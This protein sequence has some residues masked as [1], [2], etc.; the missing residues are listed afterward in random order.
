M[1]IRLGLAYDGHGFHGF[2]AQPGLRTVEGELRRALG[3]VGCRVHELRVAGRTDAG[4][5]AAGQVV[6]IECDVGPPID[7][8]APVVT[9]RLPPDIVVARAEPA[10][11]GFHARHDARGRAYVYRVLAR[12]VRDP[13]RRH[14]V[15]HVPREMDLSR[16]DAC[17]AVLRG[18]HDFR[19]FTPTETQHED[20]VRTVHHASWLRRDDELWFVVAGDRFVR[21]QVRTMVG[22]MLQVGLGEA[23]PEWFK[24]LLT[25][26][27]RADGGPTAPPH[28]LTLVGVRFE[29]EPFG[30]EL[31]GILPVDELSPALPSAYNQRRNCS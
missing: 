9:G 3:E 19:A 8:L 1:R 30:T 13:F 14:F 23:T 11:P 16:L 21:H 25:A 28:G 10:P 29:G 24:G 12:P 17:A 20:F 27:R 15:L 5:H 4:V 6:S 7:R 18:S 31:A 26:S 22:G 2:A